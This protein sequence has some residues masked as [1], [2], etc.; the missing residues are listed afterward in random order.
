MEKDIKTIVT[1]ILSILFVIAAVCYTLAVFLKNAEYQRSIGTLPPP[2]IY[3]QS[4]GR[5]DAYRRI[6]EKAKSEYKAFME[7]KDTLPEVK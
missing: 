4:I 7:K 5:D 1:V 6:I 2:E 3:N